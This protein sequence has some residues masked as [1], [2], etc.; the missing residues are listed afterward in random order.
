MIRYHFIGTDAW[1]LY[2]LPGCFRPID[3]VVSF[4]AM[5]LLST[6][7]RS[8]IHWSLVSTNS[9]ILWLSRTLSGTQAPV[10]QITPFMISLLFSE[11]D[12]DSVWVVIC[13][14]YLIFWLSKYNP[15]NKECQR[16]NKKTLQNIY[17]LSVMTFLL[18]SIIQFFFQEIT[19]P[20]FLSDNSC[21]HVDHKSCD[22]CDH[23]LSDHN[24]CR[25]FSAQLTLDSGNCCHTWV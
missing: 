3:T 22:P 13:F 19:N 20:L 8:R 1:F 10:P 18:I 23:A 17:I 14:E 16:K 2:C 25:P 24:T 11:P 15:V 21:D 6:P 4:S 9:A 7:V 12:H 5:C